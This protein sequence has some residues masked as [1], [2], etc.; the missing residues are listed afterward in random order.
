MNLYTSTPFHTFT[1]RIIHMSMAW[2]TPRPSSQDL[3]PAAAAYMVMLPNELATTPA[4][5]T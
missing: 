5:T 4:L 1:A 3:Q 2:V